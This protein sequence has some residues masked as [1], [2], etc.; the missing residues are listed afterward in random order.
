M[1]EAGL[2]GIEQDLQLPPEAEESFYEMS[3]V[4]E[5]DSIQGVLPYSLGGA[6]EATEE[7]ELVRNALG[8]PLFNAFIASRKQEWAS[9]LSSVSQ[10]EMDR[11]LSVY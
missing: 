9:Y 10:W 7:S 4:D 1:L 3:S 8:E 2:D 6:I 11:Y 5:S